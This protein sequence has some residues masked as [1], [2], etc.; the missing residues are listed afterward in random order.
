M[1]DVTRIAP[2]ALAAV[3]S[4]WWMACVPAP[5]SPSPAST[6]TTL[7]PAS[8]LCMTSGRIDSQT[9]GR[10]H[11][12][13][14]GVRGTV[15]ES[16]GIAELA[17]T[18]G[19]PSTST[20]KLAS[21]E[22]RRQ[23]GLKLRAQDTC[24]VVYVMWELEPKPDIVVSVK[25]TAGAS[26]HAE[27]GARGYQLVKPALHEDPPRVVPGAEHVL[28]VVVEGTELRVTA[29]NLMAW[30]GTLPPEA[31]TFD[32]PIGFRTD[33]GVFDFEV[34]LPTGSRPPSSCTPD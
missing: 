14:G 28:R 31:F 29:D 5:D 17:F 1:R 21:G 19:G 15:G 13:S 7:V 3:F 26:R 25:H 12:D 6:T 2:F 30:K 27:C 9:S 16:R 32:G 20:A 4:P 22:L 34:R 33:N 8:S 24:N 18:Y 11:V 23:I 10:M